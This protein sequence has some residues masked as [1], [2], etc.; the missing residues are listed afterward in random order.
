MEEAEEEKEEEQGK[1]SGE[2][3]DREEEKEVED[4]DE[5][6]G[7]DMVRGF[8]EQSATPLAICG[9]GP[10]NGWMEGGTDGRMGRLTDGWIVDGW[11]DVRVNVWMDGWLDPGGWTGGWMNGWVDEWMD[12]WIDWRKLDG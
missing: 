12:G 3:E 5:R 4:D 11:M 9:Q 6:R 1:E 8:I 10:S 2:E 7:S